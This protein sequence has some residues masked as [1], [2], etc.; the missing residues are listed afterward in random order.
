MSGMNIPLWLSRLGWKD[1]WFTD[2][3]P[4]FLGFS[5]FFVNNPNLVNVYDENAGG[6]TPI[7]CLLACEGRYKTHNETFHRALK[8]LLDLGADVDR[9]CFL[10]QS[11]VAH[12]PLGVIL[13]AIHSDSEDVWVPVTQTLLDYGANVQ[14]I[15]SFGRDKSPITIAVSDMMPKECRLFLERG[16]R[17]EW[18]AEGFKE[19]PTNPTK[20]KAVKEVLLEFKNKTGRRIAAPSSTTCCSFPGCKFS[21]YGNFLYCSAIHEREHEIVRQIDSGRWCSKRVGK[22]FRSVTHCLPLVVGS[23]LVTGFLIKRG[24]NDV[25]VR[26]IRSHPETIDVPIVDKW[27]QKETLMA[28]VIKHGSVEA[29]RAMLDLGADPYEKCSY[30]VNDTSVGNFVYAIFCLGE[31]LSRGVDFAKVFLDRNVDIDRV[32]TEDDLDAPEPPIVYCVSHVLKDCFEYLLVRGASIEGTFTFGGGYSSDPKDCTLQEILEQ[33]IQEL[34]KI[35]DS[36]FWDHRRAALQEMKEILKRFKNNRKLYVHQYFETSRTNCALS[37]CDNFANAGYD[38]CS[39]QHGRDYMKERSRC[40]LPGCYSMATPGFQYCSRE[41]GL[42]NMGA[43]NNNNNNNN[44]DG[45]AICLLPGCLKNVNPGFEYCS[46]EHGRLNMVSFCK[47]KVCLLEGCEKEVIQGFD[48]CSRAHGLQYDNEVLMKNA[49]KKCVLPGC[50]EAVIQ[51]YD[52][53]CREHGMQ[54]QNIM[55][56]EIRHCILP[57]CRNLVVPGYDFCCNQHGQQ[58]LVLIQQQQ[59]L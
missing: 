22:T 45:N 46:R 39:V 37:W 48:F 21:V 43:S 56:Q 12:T 23:E 7:G 13:E 1:N 10:E 14:N 6:R 40:L 27:Y 55:A 47:S 17:Y 24:L 54:H 44:N 5:D 25:F 3:K 53:C 20:S 52:Y 32:V 29:L 2:T 58:M 34:G 19:N 15:C 41:H 18:S 26:Y 33:E 59:G 38:C 4:D 49:R 8:T 16:A 36:E 9:L 31:A 51:G 35:H 30:L 57:G 42:Q 50:E 11:R 28:A